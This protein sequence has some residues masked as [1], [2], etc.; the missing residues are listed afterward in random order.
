MSS[1]L[2]LIASLVLS[3]PLLLRVELT[4]GVSLD[5]VCEETVASSSPLGVALR[6]RRGRPRKYSAPSRAVTLTLPESVI[7]SL[8]KV[9]SD[10]GRAIVALASHRDGRQEQASADLTVFGKRA[11]ITIRP[12]SSLERRAGIDLVP[13][14]DGRALISF[15]QARTIAELE[16]ALRDSLDDPTLDPADRQVFEG[17][18]AIL[19]QARRSEDVALR[20]RTIIVLESVGNGSAAAL[21]RT[22]TNGRRSA[23]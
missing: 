1:T 8:T 23:R 10:L 17:I 9:N 2:M 18:S 6:R 21:R 13:L 14:P 19:K 16:L 20:A 3:A 22:G 15:H 4:A 5:A 7:E 11:V 12:T